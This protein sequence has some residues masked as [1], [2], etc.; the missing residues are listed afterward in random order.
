MAATSDTL[1]SIGVFLSMLFLAVVIVHRFFGKYLPLPHQLRVPAFKSGVILLNDKPER[2]V[3]PG[4]YWLTPKRTILTCDTRPTPYKLNLEEFL[5]A[6]NFGIRIALTGHYRIT[7]PA[8]FLT[9]S[10][11]TTGDFFLALAATVRAAVLEL[12]GHNLTFART[13]LPERLQQLIAP[14]IALLGITVDTMEVTDFIPLGWLKV[15]L[16]EVS[17]PPP[18][19]QGYGPN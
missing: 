16:P 8:A 9:A 3:G 15:A 18:H 7:D 12:S 10:A 19:P 4:T 13:T 1:A 17:T 11:N 5:T 14:R 6:D 2:T